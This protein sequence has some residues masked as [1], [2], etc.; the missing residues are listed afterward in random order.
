MSNNRVSDILAKIPTLCLWQDACPGHHVGRCKYYH[1]DREAVGYLQRNC[2]DK[3]LAWRLHDALHRHP[4]L[5][6]IFYHEARQAWKAHA[7]P[8]ILY[9]GWANIQ[10]DW[11]AVYQ[12]FSRVAGRVIIETPE[13][14]Y[15]RGFREGYERGMS[16]QRQVVLRT[17]PPP[18]LVVPYS[19]PCY[20]AQEGGSY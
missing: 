10:Y 19:P 11:A 16:E 5:H 2:N 4:M 18:P 20:P 8:Y 7:V 12:P 1:P 3:N 17:T 13:E 6:K 15:A 14:T 9:S